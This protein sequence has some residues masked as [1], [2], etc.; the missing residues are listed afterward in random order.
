MW[1]YYYQREG[2]K[3]NIVKWWANSRKSEQ[4]ME[5]AWEL[6]EK[7]LKNRTLTEIL[8]DSANVG[9]MVMHSMLIYLKKKQY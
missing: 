8:N 6:L 7:D 4:D 1:A 9:D 2:I 3:I 5:D